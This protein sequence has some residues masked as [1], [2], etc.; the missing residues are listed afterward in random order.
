MYYSHLL[1][2][3]RIKLNRRENRCKE[4]FKILA[5][6]F[7]LCLHTFLC[8]KDFPQLW[9]LKYTASQGNADD[10]GIKFLALE[11]TKPRIQGETKTFGRLHNEAV[12]FPGGS[13]GKDS[14]CKAEDAG[15][16]GSIPGPRRS[17]KGGYAT[18]SSILTW[19][20]PWTEGPDGLQSTGSQRVDMPVVT[21]QAHTLNEVV[22]ILTSSETR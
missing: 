8:P 22:I 6:N 17:P 14:T 12:G 20:I 4:Y 16:V 11:Y 9:H 5:D 7:L 2:V 15:A 10:K 19:R 21:E 13:V 3:L 1:Q 18:H